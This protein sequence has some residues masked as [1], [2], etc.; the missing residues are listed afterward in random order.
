VIYQ[1]QHHRILSEKM[2]RAGLAHCFYLSDI[3]KIMILVDKL[4][5][6]GT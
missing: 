2:S 1:K 3:F 4:Y 5:T 6:K